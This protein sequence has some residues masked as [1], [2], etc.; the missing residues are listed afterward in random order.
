MKVFIVKDGPA[1]G[2]KLRAKKPIEEGELWPVFFVGKKNGKAEVLHLAYR[3]TGK[4]LEFEEEITERH[5]DNLRG[6]S[7]MN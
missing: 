2:T 4:V 3:R 1:K 6:I 7:Q 5:V